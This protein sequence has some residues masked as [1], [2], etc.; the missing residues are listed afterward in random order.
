MATTMTTTTT[1][2]TTQAAATTITTT[3]DD[4][5]NNNGGYGGWGDHHRMRKGRGH[6]NGTTHNNKIDQRYLGWE[7]EVASRR[8]WKMAVGG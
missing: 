4:N 2:M 1:T 7:E 8:M 3:V 6:D 5:N